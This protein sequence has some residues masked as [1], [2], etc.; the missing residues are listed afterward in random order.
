MFAFIAIVSS[1]LATAATLPATDLAIRSV[2]SPRI[3]YPIA[4]STWFAGGMTTVTWYLVSTFLG[5][6]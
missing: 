6:G 1:T 3:T 2:Y 4:G 5:G